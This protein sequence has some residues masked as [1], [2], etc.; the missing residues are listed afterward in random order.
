MANSLLINV[1]IGETRVG[2][3]ESGVLGE[4]YVERRRGRSPVGN[5]YLGRVTRVLPGM[6]A[7]FVDIG[8]DRAA[9]L[10]VE[11]LLPSDDL[12]EG[13]DGGT[14]GAEG[15]ANGAD[16]TNNNANGN[17]RA[18][19]GRVSRKTPIR[20]MLNEGQPLLVQVSK[21][22]DGTKGAR[23]TAHVALPGRY[24]CLCRRSSI[25]VFR[26]A[27]ATIVNGGD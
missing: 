8:L 22:P 9:F 19:R 17:K 7:A 27:S 2:L 26:S 1:D 21:W 10:H 11:D 15:N 23:V 16:G 6:Q 24:V 20:E 14:S 5:V 12:D 13:G 25:S 18:N 3:L 4:L